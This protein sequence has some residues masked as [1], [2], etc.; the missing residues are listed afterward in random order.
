MHGQSCHV[1]LLTCTYQEF[2]LVIFSLP[3]MHLT[4][5][6]LEDN[7]MAAKKTSLNNQL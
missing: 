7:G 4:L 2:E 6:K 3:L 5:V 1:C